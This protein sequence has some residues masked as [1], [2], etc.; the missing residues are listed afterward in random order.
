MRLIR[1]ICHIAN[2]I[3]ALW[4]TLLCCPTLT[5][6]GD[7]HYPS[8]LQIQLQVT[9][10]IQSENMNLTLLFSHQNLKVIHYHYSLSRDI[11]L[12]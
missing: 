2:Y 11:E 4:Y 8:V 7:K 5:L 9:H 3:E 12:P 1:G 10:F 6:V